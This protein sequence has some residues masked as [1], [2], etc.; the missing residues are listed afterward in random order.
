MHLLLM[1]LG[2]RVMLTTFVHMPSE[3]VV[4]Q[5]HQDAKKNGKYY[6]ATNQ[7]YAEGSLNLGGQP[8]GK[9]VS[10]Q[11]EREGLWVSNGNCFITNV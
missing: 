5:P 6:P 10:E 9:R 7:H 11:L 4:T 8:T 3:A 2:P 1:F